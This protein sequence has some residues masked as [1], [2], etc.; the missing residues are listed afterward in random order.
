MRFEVNICS[1]ALYGLKNV[2]TRTLHIQ[3]T[4]SMNKSKKLEHNIRHGIY[5]V[6][7]IITSS[8]E[9]YNRTALEDVYHVLLFLLVYNPRIL[10]L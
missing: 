6:K 5:V 2:Y 8:N 3:Y 1:L 10:N 7:R 4:Y 9:I